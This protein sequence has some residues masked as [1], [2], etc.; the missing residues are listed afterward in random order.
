[1]GFRFI[2]REMQFFDLFDDQAKKIIVTA[3]KFRELTASGKFGDEEIQ[4][5]R[6][7]EHEGDAITHDI[8]DK[9]NRTFITP[10]DREDIHGLAQELDNVIDMLYTT[11]KRMRIY[12]L[13]TPNN[14]LIQFADLIVQ[15]ATAVGMAINGLRT[16]KNHQ[17]IKDS[18][19]EVNHIENLGDQLRDSVIQRLFDEVKDPVEIIKW[20]EIFEEVETI[21]DICEDI[22]NLIDSIMVKQ[23]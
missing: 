3:Q 15:S 17:P 4:R 7:L 14:D 23:G 20:K 21:L 6:D 13:H 16:H 2:P 8:I 22:A 9:L 5:M 1:M 10:F 19:I 11:S 18:C 12:K